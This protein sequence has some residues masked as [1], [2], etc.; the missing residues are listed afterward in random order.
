MTIDTACSGSLISVDLACRYLD[1]GDV[2]GAIVA[3][4]NLYMN[5]EHNMDQSAMN[6]TAS[7]TGRCWTFDARA[8]EYIKAEA[9][10]TIILKRLD[11]AI[12]DGD[13]FRGVIRG[14]ATNSDGRTPG[15]ANPSADA[16]A[17][18][19]RRAYARAGISD[20]TS[21][22]Y[23]ECHGTGTLAGDPI[24]VKA[25]ASVFSHERPLPLRIGSVKSNVGHSEPAAGISGVIKTVMAIESGVIPGNPAFEIPN[26][27]IDFKASRVVLSKTVTP[28]PEGMLRRASVNSFG[29]GGS[30]AHAIIEH[31]RILM[32]DFEAP[33]VCSYLADED[34]FLP[35]AMK[36]KS[37]LDECL[38]SPQ[39]TS[40]RCMQYQRRT[41]GIYPTL[42]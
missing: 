28:W 37:L 3:G 19:I 15:I 9:I 16:Q 26:P 14:S 25:A 4:C 29:Y 8:D 24:E 6:A 20:F 18:A 39:M 10:N 12:R 38:Y 7:P 42:R 5:P 34:F 41:S 30:N 27:N 21:T 33:N 31:P 40:R 35:Q 11:D 1:T 17:A 2:D 36:M 22:A 23:L 13:P 32:P